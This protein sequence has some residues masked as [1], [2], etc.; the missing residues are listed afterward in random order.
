MAYN[1]KG[2]RFQKEIYITGDATQASRQEYISDFLH[3]E[4]SS[5]AISITKHTNGNYILKY[6]SH[7]SNEMDNLY[8][9]CS[10]KIEVAKK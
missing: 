5:S 10:S 7:F 8:A 3:N 9:A 6:V 1:S 4:F 2:Q